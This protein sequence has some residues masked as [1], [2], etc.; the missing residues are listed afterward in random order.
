MILESV[1]HGLLIWPMIEEN[2]VIR[3]KKYSELSAAKKIQADC[4]MKA[5]NIILKGLPSDIYSLV[6]RHRVAK[7]LWEKNQLLMQDS[8]FAVPVFFPRD[9]P[10]ACPNKAM[11]FL[12][13]VASS[14]F[15][16]TNN[17]LKTSSN[18]RNHATIQDGRVTVQQVQ[19]R[20]GQSYSGTSK[21]SDA[22]PVKIKAPKELPKISLMNESLKKL[23]FHLSKFDNVVKIRTTPNALTEGK[24]KKSSH[25]PKAEDTNQEKLYLLDMDLCGPMR[26]TSNEKRYILVIVE[27]YSRST[28]VRFLRLKV[29]ALEVIIIKYIKNIQVRLNAIV[30][31][32]RTDNG[33]EFVNQTLRKFYEN[34]VISH[35]TSVA[36][37]PQQ[38]GIVDRRNQTLVEAAPTMLIFSKALLFLWAVAINTAC[39]TQNHS[40]IRLPNNKTPYELMQDKKPDLSFF[41]VFGALCYPTHNNDDKGKLDA[42]S[43]IGIF[44]GYAP[45]KKAF[46][47]YNKGTWKIIKTFHVTFNELTAMAFEQFSSGPGFNKATQNFD[48]FLTSVDASWIDATQAMTEPSW[49][50]AMQEE[51]HKFERLKVWELVPCLDKVFLMLKW[52]YKVKTDEFDGVIDFE[53]SFASVFIRDHPYLCSKYRSQEYDDFP[54]GCQNG[55]LKWCSGSNTLHMESKKRLITDTPLVEKSKLDEDLLGKLVD[56]TLYRGMIGSLMC[57]TSSRPDLTYA[58]CLCAWY[59]KK[60]TDKHLNA[61]KRIFRYLKKTINMGLWYSKDT[62]MSLIAYTYADHAGCQDTRRSTSGSA[63]FL[64][65]KLVSWFSKK[66]KSTAIS[67]TKA[68]YIALSG[69]CA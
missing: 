68:K 69:C 13:V 19:G 62:G 44:V 58:I 47:I 20:Q 27:N 40:L 39:Y 11:A 51:N 8:G 28:W 66:Q 6:N 1:E 5:T 3:T 29:E 53:E 30:C 21:P 25:Q 63:Q 18:P 14:R 46:K 50:D 32:V 7:D 4:D 17:Q 38:N 55:I 33:T 24:S 2:R 37:T 35:Q 67:S 10:I 16:S 65:D 60:P 31:S 9:D 43:D 61:V 36:R 57:L 34:V 52:I 49:I 12:T 22:L 41:Y 54:N 59:Q 15:P 48:A 26:V 45:V 42:K 64:G 56:A 23:K